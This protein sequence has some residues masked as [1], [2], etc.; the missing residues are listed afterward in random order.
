MKETTSAPW[1]DST[2]AR[3]RRSCRRLGLGCLLMLLLFFSFLCGLFTLLFT[4][5]HTA[6]LND[7]QPKTP[8]A[9]WLLIDNSN[10]MFEKDG[11]GS[12]PDLLRL[13]AARL[14]LSYLGVDER[15]LIHQAG[16]IF[17][18]TG[19]ETAVSLTPLTHDQNRADL[20]AQIADPP[21]M[22]W[23]DHLA[24]LQLVQAE[25]EANNGQAR[26]AIILLTDGKP[27]RPNSMTADEEAAY[28]EALHAQSDWLAGQGIPVFII[29]LSNQTTDADS[30][31]S[32]T[33]RPLWREIS[34]AT[35]PGRFYVARTA[36]D[37]PHI[38]HDI[39]V[40]LTH[41][42]TEGVVLETEIPEEGVETTLTIPDNLT[43]L[44]LVISKSD[45]A[46]QVVI[47]TEDGQDIT[48]TSTTLSTGV[49]PQIRH[50]GSSA[51]SAEEVWVFE[52]PPAGKWQVRVHGAG[53]ITI[54]QDYKSLPDLPTDQPT[55]RPTIKPTHTHSPQPT[56]TET[57]S[58]T[59]E[60]PVLSAAEGAVITLVT[61]PPS[62]QTQT[63]K[64]KPFN[65]P[66]GL[67]IGLILI[68]GITAFVLLRQHLRRPCVSGTLRVLSHGQLVR[69]IDLD[70][71]DKTAVSLGKPPADIP[72]TGAEAAITIVPGARLEDTR[73]MFVRSE[74][75]IRLNG[76]PIPTSAPLTDSAHIDLGDGIQLRYENLRLRR[77]GRLSA[78]DLKR[79]QMKEARG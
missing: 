58:P 79:K 75:D 44:T 10:S 5:R 23:T 17:F 9:V 16:V 13:D 77:A 30:D 6:A 41:E 37:L 62:R 70:S 35:P 38:Y 11:I 74:D 22:G 20:F 45:P 27:E 4:P 57:V 68:A 60:T 54:W 76:Q 78:Q 72:L 26:P 25:L 43:Q 8:L 63:P 53:N 21:R 12:D 47:E 31:I 18:G 69:T 64:P 51:T 1:Y 33:W 48:A 28:I 49:S 61:P 32:E 29:L 55:I 66:L 2:L 65:W 50:A 56:V 71:L 73:H 3:P 24:A 40:A 34:A 15:D 67:L 42:Q 59:V 52:Q 36:R 39:V 14:F 19:A 46:Q 7:T